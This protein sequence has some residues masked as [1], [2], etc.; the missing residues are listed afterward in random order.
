MLFFY[1]GFLISKYH[2]MLIFLQPDFALNYCWWRNHLIGVVCTDGILCASLPLVIF[3]YLLVFNAIN[4]LDSFSIFWILWI[5]HMVQI[6]INIVQLF[7]ILYIT[8]T[9]NIREHHRAHCCERWSTLIGKNKFIGPKEAVFKLSH[10]LL[11]MSFS[12]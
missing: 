5:C 6:L 4:L 3:R 2:V 12:L 10:S 9:L 11:V 7:D 1:F 8:T